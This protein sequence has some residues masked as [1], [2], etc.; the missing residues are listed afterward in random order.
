MKVRTDLQIRIL[1][2]LKCVSWR[3]IYS[4]ERNHLNTL[5]KLHNRGGQVKGAEIITWRSE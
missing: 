2:V 3:I 4:K 1:S 5:Q